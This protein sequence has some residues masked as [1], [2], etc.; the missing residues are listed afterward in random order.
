MMTHV[1]EIQQP[2]DAPQLSDQQLRDLLL[3][4]IVEWGHACA[5]DLAGQ[6]GHGITTK[7]VVPVLEDLVSAGLLKH[8]KDRK[9][10]RQYEGEFQTR[11]E[12]A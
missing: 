12:L 3:R 4:Q 5:P 7:Q 9:D 6:I 11:Y 1:E 10:K 8:F 2:L